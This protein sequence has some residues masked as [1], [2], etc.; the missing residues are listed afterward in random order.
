MIEKVFLY[1]NFLF[2]KKKIACFRVREDYSQEVDI[3]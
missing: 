3:N 1:V 2:Q